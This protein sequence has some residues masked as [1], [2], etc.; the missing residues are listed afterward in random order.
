MILLLNTIVVSY[1]FQRQMSSL[2]DCLLDMTYFKLTYEISWLIIYL[3]N[4][5]FSTNAKFSE[6][7]KRS[8]S[9]PLIRTYSCTYHG[10]RNVSFSE[11]F[12][13]VINEWLLVPVKNE[14]SF[15]NWK[16][17]HG[18]LGCSI[19]MLNGLRGCRKGVKLNLQSILFLDD[20][21]TTE[22]YII[23]LYYARQITCIFEETYF[24]IRLFLN[25]EIGR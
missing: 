15:H 8:T 5:S 20:F 11:Y 18:M 3:G 21:F 22:I 14:F 23:C 6:K 17:F 12:A 4:H 1:L 19:R 10:I 9:Y 25:S 7:K 24:L 16:C 13:Y 2:C